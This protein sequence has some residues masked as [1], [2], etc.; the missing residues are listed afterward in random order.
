MKCTVEFVC[1]QQIAEYL[2]F[3][4][5]YNRKFIENFTKFGQKVKDSVIDNKD[6]LWNNVEAFKNSKDGFQIISQVGT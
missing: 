1:F 2:L 6:V 5:R 3:R 4:K